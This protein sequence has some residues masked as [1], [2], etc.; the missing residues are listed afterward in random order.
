MGLS[1]YNTTPEE[2]VKV[3]WTSIVE[4]VC[5]GIHGND[6]NTNTMY[7]IHASQTKKKISHKHTHTDAPM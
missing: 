6:T 5:R 4:D 2:K 3:A 7:T 1:S